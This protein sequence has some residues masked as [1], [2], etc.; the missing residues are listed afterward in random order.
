MYSTTLL[1]LVLSI[2]DLTCHDV[3]ERE[4]E[5]FPAREKKKNYAEGDEEGSV[6]SRVVSDSLHKT[7]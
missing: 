5:I 7:R 3:R 2:I 4:S 6:F 1:F